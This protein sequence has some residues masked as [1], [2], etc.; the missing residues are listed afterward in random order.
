MTAKKYF[1]TNGGGYVEPSTSVPVK[2]YSSVTTINP[3]L[4]EAL[5]KLEQ[6][7]AELQQ[8]VLDAGSI[9][10]MYTIAYAKEFVKAKSSSEGGKAPSDEVAKQM[11]L[12]SESMANIIEAYTKSKLQI[13]LYLELSRNVRKQIDGLKGTIFEESAVSNAY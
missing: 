4:A 11:V 10:A 1:G 8:L 3:K 7:T 5:Q 12:S 13:D 6:I 2:H 9:Q